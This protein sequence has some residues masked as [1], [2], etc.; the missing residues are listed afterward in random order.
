MCEL[1]VGG[2]ERIWIFHGGRK[3]GVIS[4]MQY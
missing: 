3:E 2:E 1:G 4:L